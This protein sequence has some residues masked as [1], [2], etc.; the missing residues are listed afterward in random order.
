MFEAMRARIASLRFAGRRACE[1]AAPRI[2]ARARDDSRTKRGNVPSF[3]DRF[4]DI[5]TTAVADGETIEVTAADWVMARAKNLDQPSAWAGIL[6]DA[7]R[8]EV[9]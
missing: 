5:P 6:A 8:E 7:V 1:A 9:K 3:G 2:E 4:G